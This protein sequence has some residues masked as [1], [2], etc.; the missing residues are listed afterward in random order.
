M[1]NSG[2]LTITRTDLLNGLTKARLLTIA[3]F[4]GLWDQENASRTD[5]YDK[6]LSS[7]L[8]ETELLVDL[9][10][11][12]EIRALCDKF[13][14]ING[15]SNQDDKYKAV[16][17]AVGSLKRARNLQ[18]LDNSHQ[19]DMLISDVPHYYRIQVKTIDAKSDDQ[20]VENKWKGSQIDCVIHFA[21][22][23]NW[24]YVIPALTES[25]RK[26]SADGH[27]KFLQTRNEFLKA[28]HKV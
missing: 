18:L 9:L 28:F 2:K 6:L 27:V 15:R 16:R 8:Y 20:H 3:E 26:L 7:R 10:Q 24:G 25:N 12:K 22:N 11:P 5:L 17:V 1:T 4:V 19:T 14:L 13:R 21:R 23:S